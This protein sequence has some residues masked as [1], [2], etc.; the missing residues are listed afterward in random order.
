M[1]F[2][3]IYN[4]SLKGNTF[5]ISMQTINLREEAS[6]EPVSAV[7]IQIFQL[8]YLITV[9]SQLTSHLEFRFYDTIMHVTLHI[10][11]LQYFRNILNGHIHKIGNM[12]VLLLI[13]K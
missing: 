4:K 8:P 6:K 12:I 5:Y 11:V 7:N 1:Q 2:Q 13:T 3:R 9:H 10:N